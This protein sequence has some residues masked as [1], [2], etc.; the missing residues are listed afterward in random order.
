MGRILSPSEK[1]SQQK[2]LTLSPLLKGLQNCI[3]SL[4]SYTY[5]YIFHIYIHHMTTVCARSLRND[6]FRYL[7]VTTDGTALKH[8]WPY[9]I[10]LV[11]SVRADK[12]SEHLIE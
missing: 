3:V 11:V 10:S 8:I 12:P 7:F 5:I 4:Q 9:S 6:I 2:I 1:R